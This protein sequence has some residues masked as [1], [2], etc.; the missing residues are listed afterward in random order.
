MGCG[1]SQSQEGIIGMHAYSILDVQEVINVDYSFFQSTGVAH[2]N[3]SGFVEFDGKVRLLR[4]RNPHGKGEWKG[5]FSDKSQ[6]WK[7]LLFASNDI[8]AT[9]LQRTMKNDGS[10]WID[11]DNFLMGFHDVDVVLAFL[12]NHAK[13]FSSN[14]PEKKSS[15]RCAR[16]F[17]VS[18]LDDLGEPYTEDTVE[19]YIMGVQKTKRGAKS[20][21]ADRK[22]S[23]KPCDLGV[24]VAEIDHVVGS[25]DYESMT[26]KMVKGEMFGLKRNGHFSVVLK[27][28]EKNKRLL[29]MP[30]SFGHPAATDKELSF[31]LR[32]VSDAPLFIQECSS[33]PRMDLAI[34]SFC[35]PHNAHSNQNGIR[36]VILKG[37]TYCLIQVQCQKTVF[38]YLVV[39]ES[40][41]K[42][43]KLDESGLCFSIEANCRGMFCRTEN[44][45]LQHQTVAKG[46]KFT[47]A[48]RRYNC[49]FLHERLSRLLLV[50]VQSGQDTEFTFIV[51]TQ[52]STAQKLGSRTVNQSSLDTYLD[53]PSV[54]TQK[55]YKKRGIFNCV[56]ECPTFDFASN[57][58]CLQPHA[59]LEIGP[60]LDLQQAMVLSRDEIELQQA[61]EMSKREASSSHPMSHYIDYD[62]ENTIEASKNS[63]I[64]SSTSLFDDD[65][66]K[67]L[68]FSLQDQEQKPRA[69]VT[70]DIVVDLTEDATPTKRQKTDNSDDIAISLDNK[71]SDSNA[72][73]TNIEDKK[74]TTLDEKRKLAREAAL[75]RLTAKDKIF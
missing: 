19:L 2:G 35:R 8:E 17:E 31:V 1:T 66:S 20:G 52:I 38:L 9:N 28:K 39:N 33:V 5:D 25:I 50:L 46:K 10:F 21:R 26:F 47:A 74:P 15:H 13:S 42:K 75:K 23:Y 27:R 45:L 64:L 41:L 48:H 63:S 54:D 59:A 68:Q 69:K 53:I 18:L 7:K 29:V 62:L 44:G 57:L 22:V 16:A 24:L 55:D 37:S 56:N 34:Q 11:Y 60:D 6:I 30:I 73:A 67:A 43:Q 14:F 4:I 49:E 61:L 3:V 65:L 72:A 40:E 70:K 58:K 32:F 51:A 71:M 12:G 36:K